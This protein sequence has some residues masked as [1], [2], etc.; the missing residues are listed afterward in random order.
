MHGQGCI[1]GLPV[2]VERVDIL[3][4]MLDVSNDSRR[5]R[6]ECIVKLGDEACQLIEAGYEYV[7]DYKE[8]LARE[9]S[10][11]YLQAV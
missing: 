8:T 2:F 3:M 5:R 9:A 7:T 4:R 11:T 6:N 10:P 1:A